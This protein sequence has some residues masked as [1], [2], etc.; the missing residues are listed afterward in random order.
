MLRL[1]LSAFTV[2]FV[3]S[4]DC[5]AFLAFSVIQAEHSG[6]QR[7]PSPRTFGLELDVACTS[8]VICSVRLNVAASSSIIEFCQFL[9]L[10]ANV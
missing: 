7:R 2:H 3:T 6:L 1:L 10:L 8:Q 9:R 4:A 5:H